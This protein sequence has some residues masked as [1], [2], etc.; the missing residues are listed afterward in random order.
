MRRTDGS[1]AWAALDLVSCL[2]LVL[3]TLVAPPRA[4][5]AKVTTQGAYAV[6]LQWPR[7]SRNDLDLYVENPAGKVA[8]YGQRDIGGVQLEHDD[9]GAGTGTSYQFG[10]NYER[11]V[12]RTTSPGTYA[13]VIHV[14]CKRDPGPERAD[15]QLWSLGRNQRPLET[16][17]VTL[18]T[19]GDEQTAFRWTVDAAGKTTS[20]DRLPVSLRQASGVGC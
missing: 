19:P 11:T 6:V 16:A 13:A 7:R 14:F 20:I 10:P 1:I 2:L 8:W 4:R 5:S 3:Y 17:T 18:G 15:V 9:L 12:V